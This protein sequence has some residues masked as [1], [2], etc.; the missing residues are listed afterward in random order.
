VSVLLIQWA[1]GPGAYEVRRVIDGATA[2]LR[3][4]RS[5]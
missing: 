2:T 4:A 5:A 1:V 3:N